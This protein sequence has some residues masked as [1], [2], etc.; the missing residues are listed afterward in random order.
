M[1]HI[2]VSDAQAWLE[3]TKANLTSLDPA[4]ENT[5]SNNV[6]GRL[7]DTYSDPT[8]GV[9]TWTDNTNTPALVKQAIA[10][11]YA[12]WYFDRQYSE[13]VAA[14][15]TSYGLVLRNY[16]ETLIVGII[17]SSIE[18]VE[19]S[20]N[21]P[22]TAPGGAM[23]PNDVSSTTAALQANTDRDNTSLGPPMFGVQKVF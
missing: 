15:G 11:L 7:A 10:M 9:P 3:S 16:A 23:Y 12:G 19:I 4:L 22:A 17:N 1:A 8:F 20:P 21:M 14:E 13:V 2:L 18:L 6:L 5:I